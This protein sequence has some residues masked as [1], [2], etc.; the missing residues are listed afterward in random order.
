[1][2]HETSTIQGRVNNAPD[3]IKRAN[4]IIKNTVYDNFDYLKNEFFKT[5]DLM[6]SRCGLFCLSTRYDSLPMWAHY[7]NN[8]K[9][10]VVEFDG[11]QNYFVGDETGLL[12]QLFD[13]IYTDKKSGVSFERGS[14]KAIFLEK[15][16]DWSYEGE[17]RIIVNL[18]SCQE[19]RFGNDTL[20]TKNINKQII[21]RV[22]LGWKIDQPTKKRIGQE[23]RAISP[24]INVSEAT[25]MEGKIEL[26][27]VVE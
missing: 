12:N 21:T 4:E 19:S 6:A 24:D 7:A 14:Y 20:Y 26:S 2:R 18:S 3:T 13:V 27:Q 17:K 8:A 11:I 1:M 22:I 16:N 9:G 23:V 25:I 15:D 10:Y 5:V